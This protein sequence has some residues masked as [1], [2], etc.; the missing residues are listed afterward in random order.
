M[1]WYLGTRSYEFLKEVK[2]IRCLRTKTWS[3]EVNLADVSSAV[4]NV[5]EI[6]KKTTLVKKVL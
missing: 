3:R 1:C 4:E 2:D 5:D 6:R